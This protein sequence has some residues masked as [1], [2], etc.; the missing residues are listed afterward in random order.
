MGDIKNFVYMLF[1]AKPSGRPGAAT[2]TESDRSKQMSENKK[3]ISHLKNIDSKLAN[4]IMDEIIER[5]I[6]VHALYLNALGTKMIL[7]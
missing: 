5:Y 7:N 4:H 2:G 1:Q 3:K 6:S